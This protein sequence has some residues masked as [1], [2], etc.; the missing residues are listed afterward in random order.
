[1]KSSTNSLEKVI[2]KNA[3]QREEHADDPSQ[4]MES[5]L[6]LYD[7]V[8]SLQAIAANLDLYEYLL[9]GNRELLQ[10]LIQLLEHPNTD[11]AASVIS[12]F[13]EWVD[14]NLLADDDSAS[15]MSNLAQL[16]KVILQE[17]LETIVQTN[18]GKFS[19]PSET[20]NDDDDEEDDPN[21]KGTDNVLSLLEN[22]LEL[23][24]VVTPML[25]GILASSSGDEATAQSVAAFITKETDILGWLL[26]SLDKD[27]VP[28]VFQSRCM[29]L[30]SLLLQRE[31]VHQIHPDFSKIPK[32][33]PIE[34]DNNNDDYA[35]E[36]PSKKSKTNGDTE[37]ASSKTIDGIELLLQAIGRFRKAQPKN[38]TQV[39]FLENACIILSSCLTFSSKNVEAFLQGQGIELVLRCL[40]EKVHAG[41]T[42]LK[43]LDFFG[44][45]AVH[46][47]AAE[48]IV[49]A[50][51]LKYLFPLFLS[52]GLPKPY[53]FEHATKKTKRA[54]KH[55]LESQ[56]IRVLYCLVRHLDDK[57]PEDA[58]PRLIAKFVED[59]TKCD[60]LVELLL[61]YDQKARQAEYQFYRS[62]VEESLE[63]DEDAIQLAALDAKLQGGGELCHRLGAM[64]AYLCC[65]SQRCHA[66]ILDQLKLQQ[67]GISLVKATVQEFASV[68]GPGTTHQEQLNSYLSKI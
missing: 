35:K 26:A 30:L 38:D 50:G 17:A 48:H 54:W 65:E 63:G 25:G 44:S 41:G 62:D 5:E 45:F 39:E 47:Q 32:Y 55:E 59:E 42:A 20:E 23:D 68:L 8:T 11:I 46:K 51:G 33:N 49:K 12:L 6:Q 15:S 21:L 10:L 13:L 34:N 36:P 28:E 67:S 29:E 64:A 22:L 37:E 60:R 40:K 66:R 9:Q 4:Y 31:D 2:G 27:G 24:M 14:P 57:S 18:L 3:L 58:K 16:A 56:T 7:H 61:Q 43:L 52:K 19:V 53:N 1:L